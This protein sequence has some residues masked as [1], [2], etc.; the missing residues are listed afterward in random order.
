MT[1]SQKKLAAHN[2]RNLIGAHDRAAKKAARDGEEA[3]ATI[4]PVDGVDLLLSD[5]ARATKKAA[6]AGG[7]G[8]IGS[9]HGSP[10]QAPVQARAPP[11]RMLRFAD[12]IECTGLSRSSGPV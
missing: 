11:C 3:D 12:V 10:E 9:K 5:G 8:G 4:G 1:S 2:A 7:V 6:R